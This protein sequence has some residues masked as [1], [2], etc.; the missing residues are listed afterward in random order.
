MNCQPAALPLNASVGQSQSDAVLAPVRSVTL[1]DERAGDQNGDQA[2][3]LTLQYCCG[4]LC[5]LCFLAFNFLQVT[6]G[7]FIRSSG[8]WSYW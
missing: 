8:I 3:G 2:L 6:A 5:C 4:V 1:S 7:G